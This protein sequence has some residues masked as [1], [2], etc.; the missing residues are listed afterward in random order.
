MTN[1]L[2][3]REV[4][5][6]FIIHTNEETL[7]DCLNSLSEQNCS[8]NT[9]IVNNLYPMS[10]AFQFMPDNCNTKY[11]IQLDADM[12]IEKNSIIRLY[13]IISNTNFFTYRVSG[14]LYEKGFGIGGHI[15]CWKKN[16]FNFFKFKD[17][18]TV[19]RNFHRRVRLFGFKN[20]IINDFF[21]Y[22]IP[23]HSKF[24]LYLKTKSDV[25]KWKFLNRPFNKYAKKLLDEI[26]YQK[27]NIKL[28]GY[29]FGTLTPNK[30]VLKSKNIFFERD[31]LNKL[32]KE[33]DFS[34]IAYDS[35]LFNEQK[36]YELIEKNYSNF[37]S[38]DY[39]LKKLL[40]IEYFKLLN[41]SKI[42]VNRILGY[43]IN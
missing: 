28:N 16:I 40:L 27:D 11:F 22:H 21:G 37:K 18:R 2:D 41:Y 14:Q 25:E 42:N 12:I 8:F 26:I 7:H 39:N 1:K 29:I 10:K 33:F 6:V 15:K 35:N 3:L 30:Y 32:K 38:D 9:I 17:V 13:K 31:F 5:T 23:R 36:L 19:D 4:L 43:I 20:K 34:D 24:S